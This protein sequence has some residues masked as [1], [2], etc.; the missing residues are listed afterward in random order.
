M[1][2]GA[3]ARSSLVTSLR[4]YGRSR[5]LWLLL[6]A[7]PVGARY[8]IPTDGRSMTMAFDGHLPVM[9]AAV[10]GVSLGIVVSTILLPIGFLYL[11]SNV[12]RRQP[13]QVE[14]VTPASRIG[15]ALGRFAADVAVFAGVLAALSVAGLFLAALILGTAALDPVDV[16]VPLWVIAAPTLMLL[17]GLRIL[18]DA[19]PLTRGGMGETFFFIGWLAALS[20]GAIQAMAPGAGVLGA[21]TDLLGFSQPLMGSAPPGTEHFSLGVSEVKPGRVPIDPMAAIA[22]PGYLASRAVWAALAVLLAAV[23]GLIYRPHRQKRQPVR[24]GRL[25]RML[26]P[27]APPAADRAAPPAQRARFAPLELIRAEA[28]L[29]LPGKPMLLLA[30]GIA[31][32]GACVD[33]RHVASPAAL[34]LLIF[35]LTAHAGR[36]EAAG[37][38]RLTRTMRF[39]PFARRLACVAAGTLWMVA[40]ALPAAVVRL[41]PDPLALAAVTGAAAAVVAIVLAMV[42]RSAFAPR[43]V[44]LILWYGYLAA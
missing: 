21:M 3:V 18:F 10:I 20:V 44:L 31:A 35:G 9:S 6:L 16:L 34:L 30:L 39:D 22:A 29:I 36:S 23:A 15:I 24:K 33:F 25:A 28:A 11:R 37:L 32:L 1:S 19:R 17:A 27:G 2:I 8:L 42:S 13:W 12:T 7:G 40:M 26:A 38:L 43:L 14:D 5:G 41:S 4:R